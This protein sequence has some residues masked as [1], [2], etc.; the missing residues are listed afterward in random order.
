MKTN[1]KGQVVRAK[2][3]NHG[4]K[5]AGA[6]RKKGSRDQITVKALLEMIDQKTGG[7]DYEEILVE[8]FMQA[9]I[10]DDRALVYKYHQLIL[11]KVMNS[12][13]KIEVT[14]SKEAIEAKQQAF[15]AALAKLTGVDQDK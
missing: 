8:D 6:G 4:G 5:R 7:R 10:N 3:A 15:A 11:Q 12:L 13:A 1:E 2:S 14:D 9:R